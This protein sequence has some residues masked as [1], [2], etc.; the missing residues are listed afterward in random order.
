MIADQ[1]IIDSDLF[2][3]LAIVAMFLLCVYIARRL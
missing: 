1:I 2:W 3:A